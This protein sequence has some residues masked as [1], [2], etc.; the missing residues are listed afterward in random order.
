MQ[1]IDQAGKVLGQIAKKNETNTSSTQKRGSGP[2][3]LSFGDCLFSCTMLHKKLTGILCENHIKMSVGKFVKC[4]TKVARWYKF[5]QFTNLYTKLAIS[6]ELGEET[7]CR[8]A[9]LFFALQE[10]FLSVVIRYSLNFI[11][12]EVCSTFL[13]LKGDYHCAYEQSVVTFHI[14]QQLSNKQNSSRSYDQG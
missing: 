5:L 8:S 9:L 3:G 4:A 2:L 13:S 7:F 12:R 11:E 6:K 10:P 14:F 1:K